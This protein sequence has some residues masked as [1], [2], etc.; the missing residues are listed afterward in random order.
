MITPT[1]MNQKLSSERKEM[2]TKVLNCLHDPLFSLSELPSR[3]NDNEYAFYL[4]FPYLPTRL[5]YSTPKLTNHHILHEKN[6][7]KTYSK[8]KQMLPVLST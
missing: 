7:Y 6:Y 1:V 4:P 8:S 2:P 5:P 3:C